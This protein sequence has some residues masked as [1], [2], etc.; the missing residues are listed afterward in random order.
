MTSSIARAPRLVLILLTRLTLRVTVGSGR[1]RDAIRSDSGVSHSDTHTAGRFARHSS[2]P[3]PH[4]ETR[5]PR[6][7][8]REAR[9]G[10]IME[11]PEIL[12]TILGILSAGALDNLSRCRD[13]PPTRAG[14]SMNG[15]SS[16]KHLTLDPAP[17]VQTL[18]HYGQPSARA[19]AA[20]LFLFM[21][22][23]KTD[24][25]RNTS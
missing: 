5:S 21:A 11:A 1:G 16:M 3:R 17:G 20:R 14:P 6:F 13:R 22:A 15:S 19:H 2:E 8:S 4:D 23:V 24:H 9:Y 25:P 7:S 12:L 18:R 10:C